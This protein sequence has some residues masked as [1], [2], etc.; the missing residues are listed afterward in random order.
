MTLFNISPQASQQ[1]PT[2]FS[3]SNTTVSFSLTTAT[4]TI[5]PDRPGRNRKGAMLY[6]AG[7]ANAIFNLGTTVSPTI[8][9]K[10]RDGSPRL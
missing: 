8:F 2:S 5:A 6:N 10:E 3:N 9:T 7:T 1:Q 4:T